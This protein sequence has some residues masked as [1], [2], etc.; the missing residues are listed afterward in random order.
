MDFRSFMIEGVDGE[1][2]FLPEGGFKGS[3]GSFSVKSVNNKTPILD[4]EPIS[5][6]LPENVADNIINSINTSSSDELPPMHPPYLL[7][8]RWASKVVGDASTPLDVDSN[9]NIHEFPS[10]REL[11]DAIDCHWVVAH[12]IDR[13][14]QDRAA[15]VSQFVPDIAMKLVHSDEMGVLVARLVRASIIHGRCTAFEEI[16]KLKEP[17]VLE[18]MSG[19]RMSSKDEY[20]RARED[21]DNASFPFLSEFTSNPYAFVEQLLSIKPRSLR[22]LKA[23]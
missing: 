1:F 19:Y 7:S 17:F 20:D 13:L 10:G 15:I 11:K 22:S 2:N 5:A 21:M 12:E 8:L 6:A 9:P 18:K 4:A 23:P 3:Q 16:A 14:R